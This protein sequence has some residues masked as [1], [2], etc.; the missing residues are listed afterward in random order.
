MACGLH[1]V[2]TPAVT[3]VC[4]SSLSPPNFEVTRCARLCDCEVRDCGVCAA[5]SSP[6]LPGNSRPAPIRMTTKPPIARMASFSHAWSCMS[7]PMPKKQDSDNDTSKNS[8]ISAVSSARR[9]GLV[10]AESMTNR[11]CIPIGATYANPNVSPWKKNP[12]LASYPSKH[13][14][15]VVINPAKTN[16]IAHFV[17]A[18]KTSILRKTT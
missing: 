2:T 4:S 3:M 17:I 12:I 6:P 11:F 9:R 14:W 15:L 16:Q 10:S 1:H 8:T 7:L 18:G 13:I 5:P